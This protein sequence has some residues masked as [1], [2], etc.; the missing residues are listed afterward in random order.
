MF[1]LRNKRRL[2]K[3]SVNL[4]KY[5]PFFI[6]FPLPVMLKFTVHI[7]A[8][9]L[10]TCVAKAVTSRRSRE[11]QKF[12]TFMV[13]LSFCFFFEIWFYPCNACTAIFVVLFSSIVQVSQ[14]MYSVIWL[15]NT[16]WQNVLI[17]STNQMTIRIRS[18]VRGEFN[19]ASAFKRSLY[20][21]QAIHITNEDR[22]Q[23]TSARRALALLNSSQV[24]REW[25][26]HNTTKMAVH[27]SH[28]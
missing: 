14:Q 25:Y 20:W 13:L 15:V 4:N 21:C 1:S 9:H 6:I 17:I 5:G 8:V 23:S 2:M 28:G 18:N 27:A 16:W 19:N 3:K 11:Y 26:E 7:T 24:S 10:F 22:Y 12:A